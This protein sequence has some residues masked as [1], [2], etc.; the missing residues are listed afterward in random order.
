MVTRDACLFNHLLWEYKIL[1]T[2]TLSGKQIGRKTRPG[3][4]GK[5][6]GSKTNNSTGYLLRAELSE[7]YT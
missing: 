4:N 6:P 5:A 3:V 1:F 2:P 7:N